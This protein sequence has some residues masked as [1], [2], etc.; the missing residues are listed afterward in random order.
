MTGKSR[1][2]Y[3]PLFVDLRG[4]TVLVVGGGRVAERKVADLLRSGAGVIL[5]SPDLTEKLRGWAEDGKIHYIKGVFSP[6]CLQNVWLVVA[7]TDDPRVQRAV[8]REAT[9]RRIFC[10]VVDQPEFCSFIVPASVRRGD[11]HIAISTGGSS[12]ALAAKIRQDLERCYRPVYAAYVEV[13]RELRR[14]IIDTVPAGPD[15]KELLSRLADD[16]VPE[17]MEQGR[18]VEVESWARSLA[19][20]RAEKLVRRLLGKRIFEESTNA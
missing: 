15:R 12:P 8:F 9:E 18:M 16:R 6:E 7:A 20:Q 2:T 13:I 4:R 19:G 11:L 5:V 17:M 1:S 3:Y 10:N 14:L